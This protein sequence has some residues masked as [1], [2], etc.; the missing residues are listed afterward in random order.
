MAGKLEPMASEVQK[1]REELKMKD[2]E[3]KRLHSHLNRSAANQMKAEM[4]MEVMSSLMK[5]L[6]C[7]SND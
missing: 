1:L 6:C 4:E 5:Y 3:V 7:L 2:G